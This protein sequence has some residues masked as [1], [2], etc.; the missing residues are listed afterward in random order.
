MIKEWIVRQIDGGEA[1]LWT[2]NNVRHHE[3]TAWQ[4]AARI[5]HTHV[6]VEVVAHL[7]HTGIEM[8]H[9]A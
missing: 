9:P 2:I 4:N 6:E 1:F 7:V 5:V 3:N 8:F